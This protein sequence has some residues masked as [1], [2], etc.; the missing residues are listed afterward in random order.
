MLGMQNCLS[1]KIIRE[2]FQEKKKNVGIRQLF[3][4]AIETSLETAAYC[5]RMPSIESHLCLESQVPDSV[6]FVRQQVMAHGCAF[7]HEMINHG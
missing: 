2:K 5:T 4:T 3:I 6:Y 1:L 7:A